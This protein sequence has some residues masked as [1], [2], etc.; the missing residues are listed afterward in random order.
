MRHKAW[1]I[2]A[3]IVVV[4]LITGGL[5]WAG[6]RTQ[7]A[8]ATEETPT[9]GLQGQVVETSGEGLVIETPKGEVEVLT[10]SATTLHVPGLTK[11]QLADIEVGVHVM[12][13]AQVT[14]DGRLL[15]RAVMVLPPRRLR[16]NVLR[17]TVVRTSD[18]RVLVEMPENETATLLITDDTHL[19]IPG[20]PPT[21]TVDLDTGDPVL[22]IG[23]PEE[24]QDGQ[25][26]ITAR[27][28]VVVSDKDLPKVV[29][30]G[31]VLAVTRQTIVVQTGRGER[32]ITIVPRTRFWPE[33]EADSRRMLFPGER[34]LAFGQPT[35]YGQ[36]YTGAVIIPGPEP[37][38]RH[39]LRGTVV[40]MDAKARTLIVETEVRGEI[41]VVAGDDTR[42]RIPG[43]GAPGFDDIEAGDCMVAIG[44][45]ENRSRARFLA[46][47]I[48]V[49]TPP[50]E[51]VT[52]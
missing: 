40:E 44:G 37:L 12:I 2:A 38:A 28:V 21:T 41:T 19:W 35:E 51:E 47:G 31:Q 48:Y 18:D 3:A 27:L 11:A 8:W 49:V 30:Q 43:V 16:A 15:A 52:P 7:V 13:R 4:A 17:G 33:E 29:V 20:E 9:Q 6:E 5:A 1:I 22:A 39:A 14:E 34:I 24:L 42:Y 25:K 10:T 23:R 26:T 50:A 46:R 36:W 32:A 45:F